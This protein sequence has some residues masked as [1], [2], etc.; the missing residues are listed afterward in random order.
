MTAG[1]PWTAWFLLIA[2]IAPGLALTSFF[3]FKRRKSRDDG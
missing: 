1:L 2:A 3:Y